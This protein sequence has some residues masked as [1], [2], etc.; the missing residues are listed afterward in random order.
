M[1]VVSAAS[2]GWTGPAIARLAQIIAR[3]VETGGRSVCRIAG[4]E[5]MRCSGN[6]IDCPVAEHPGR[7]IGILDDQDEAPGSI[8]HPRPRQ[9]RRDVGTVAGVLRQ[10]L[11]AGWDC[12]AVKHQGHGR[13]LRFAAYTTLEIANV[14]FR[15][16][17]GR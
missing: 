5:T 15:K 10:Y 16:G 14:P 8:G 9:R 11:A 7:C 1:V 4:V 3:L 2:L 17:D 13:L 6:V 12:R